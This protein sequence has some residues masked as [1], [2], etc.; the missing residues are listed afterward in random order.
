MKNRDLL[1]QTLVFLLALLPIL[2][3]E[4]LSY[5]GDRNC[6][7]CHAAEHNAWSG[8]HHDLAMQ[9]ADAAT[10]LGDFNRSTFDY[11][12]IRTTFYKKGDS[13]MVRTD[14]PDGKLHDYTIAFTFGVTPLQQY[15]IPF[16]DG[17]FQVLDIA[18]DSRKKDA[19][20]QRW[21]H[22]HP[23]DNVTGGDPLHWTGP[24]LNWNYMCADCHSTNLKKNYDPNTHQYTTTYNAINV[25]CE[26]CHGPGSA[27]VAWAESP[28][29]DKKTLRKGLTI[30]LS[31]FG[32]ER[33]KIDTISG[34]PVRLVDI[35]H[36]EVEL[37]AKCHARRSQFDDNFV[38]GERFAEHYLPARLSASLYFPDGKIK[39]EV[40]VYGSF[41]QSKM[42]AQGVTCSDCHDPHSLQRKAAGDNVCNRCHRRVDYDTPKHHFHG[43]DEAGCIDCHM[44]PRTYMGVDVRNDHSFRIPRPDHS[45]GTDTPNACNLCHTDRSAQWATDTLRKWYGK[46][47]VG[48]Q[49]FA[50][51]LRALRRGSDTA[52]QALYDVLLSDAPAIAKATVAA[53]LGEF[54]SQQTYMTTLQM[55]QSSDG[56][57]RLGALQA[58]EAFSPKLRI[59]KSVEMLDDPLKTV[60]TE[61][62]R[63]L[64]AL[65]QADLPPGIKTKLDSAIEA[66]RQTLLFNAERAES[67]TAL[68]TLYANLGED[69]MAVKAYREALRL[70]PKF[71]P[72]YI[73]FAHYYQQRG[74]EKEAYSVLKT[75]MEVIEESA[76]IEHALGLW[77]VRNGEPKKALDALKR[78]ANLAPDNARYQYVYAVALSQ[79]D[80]P[81]S[82]TLL[83]RSLARHSGHLQ[84]L[85]AL[86]YYHRQLGHTM[87][88][89][90]YGQK[91]QALERFTPSLGK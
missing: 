27:H 81:A 52:P 7:Q 91:A 3:A 42:Y 34:K 74:R 84:T 90:L 19:G 57:I 51:A 65:P 47:P 43:K 41:L 30:D 39:D 63:Q 58:L 46:T 64:S 61:A 89:E 80:T 71:V 40:Y 45:I 67:Q 6:Q 24:N 55:L 35:D 22:L 76:E 60:R 82:I 78:A 54:P 73:N 5:L 10:V 16:P 33:W 86:A 4:P 87:Q 62:A 68:G 44:P 26:A 28:T 72:A 66:Y 20:G 75:G 36:T 77:Y 49:N 83:E 9:K 18:W 85:Y 2:H 69:K 23:D 11:N 70:Q 88:A 25:S 17:K 21:F 37:C 13:F 59:G 15:L 79:T 29:K 1:K 56:A 38:P 14:G 53:H 48:K 12:G 31:A 32:K 50:P 8:S